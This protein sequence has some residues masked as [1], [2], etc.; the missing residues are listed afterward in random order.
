MQQKELAAQVQR[1][2]SLSSRIQKL[3]GRISQPDNTAELAARLN[4]VEAAG[5]QPDGTIEEV[6]KLDRRLSVLETKPATAS[7]ELGELRQWL[8]SVSDDVKALSGRLD[9]VEKTMR[10]QAGADAIDAALLLTLLQM[11]DAVAAG[12]PFTAEYDAFAALAHERHDIAA[13]SAPLAGAAQ[14]G[15]AGR[16]VLRR[17][18]DALA[19]EI[20]N[21]EP[22][23]AAADW[24]GQ[25]W[26]R[27]RSLVT[28]RRI[29]GAG[30]SAAEA[31][32]G[33]AQRA[34]AQGDL[35]VAI[36]KLETLTGAPAEA[37]KP[38][39]QMAHARQTVEQALRRTEQLLTAR[40][41]AQHKSG[42]R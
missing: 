36:G 15:V 21:A 28:I 24:Q 39:L 27:M 29:A 1:L 4:R 32:V 31:A 13:A 34:L 17:R 9:A 25:T 22:P 14:D 7:A 41:G 30:Q 11:R 10:A 33:A 20:T 2:E 8:D 23:P 16:E 5:R 37:A 40:L 19:S 6:Q 38:W 26:A 12:R 42:Q 3:E 35:G 18:L